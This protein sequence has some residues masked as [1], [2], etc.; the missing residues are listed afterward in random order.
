MPSPEPGWRAPYY[1]LALFAFVATAIA[2]AAY[3]FYVDQN[4]AVER[5]FQNELLTIAEMKAG[6][7]AAWRSERIGSA[8]VILEDRMALAALNRIVT[9]ASS[10]D[11][12]AEIRDWMNGICRHLR[13]ANAIL[14]DRQGAPLLSAGQPFGN[15]NHYRAIAEEVLRAGELVMRDFHQDVPSGKVHLGLNFPLRLTPDAEPFGAFLLGI[16]PGD[17]LY[18]V[19]Q[20]WPVLSTTGET[21]LVRREGDKVVYLNDVGKSVPLQFSL[22]ITRTDVA[23]VQAVLGTEGIV[24]ALDYRGVPVIA[25]VRRVPQTPWYIVAKVGAAEVRANALQR[26]LDLGLLAISLI[27]AAGGGVAFVWRRQQLRSY[28]ER[29]EAAVAHRALLGRYD[30]LLRFANDTIL[31]ADDTGRIVEANDRASSTYGY[32]REELQEMS[33]RDLWH[34]NAPGF[35]REWQKT[36]D[37]GSDLFETVHRS[38]NGGEIPVE[39]SARLIEVG[40]KKFCQSIIRDISERKH[41]DAEKFRLEQQLAQAQKMESIGRLAGG[42]AHD[43]NNHLTVISGYCNLVLEDLPPADPRREAIEEIRRAGDRAAALTRQLLAFSRK[44]IATPRSVDLNEVIAESG[45]ML[46]RLIGEDI[47][48][49]TR[50]A[51]QPCCVKA[52]PAQM[53]QILMNLAVNARDA[54]PDGGRIRIETTGATVDESGAGLHAVKPGRYVLLTVSDT[55][56]GMNPETLAQIFEP[57]FTTKGVGLGTG[58]GLAT[59]YGIVRQSGGW[60]EAHSEPGHG[61]TFQIYL[62]RVESGAEPVSP[63]AAA[64]KPGGARVLV[65]EDEPQLRKLAVK[66]LRRLGYEVMEAADGPAALSLCER[67]ADPIDLLMTDVIMPGMNGRE[68][69]DKLLASRPGLHVL[70]VSGYTASV[71]ENEGRLGRGTAY[72]A[73]PYSPEQLS[74]KVREILQPSK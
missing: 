7:M 41:A 12:R 43:F 55:G 63:T 29:Y 24:R 61:A 27:L 37:S 48:I 33:L 9:G 71:I 74:A 62:P 64:A 44:Q 52:D 39:V 59:V 2:G 25:G 15:R 4:A 60:I 42:V 68:L 66:M 28:K 51:A 35:E 72:L 23:G 67:Y 54:M 65:V 38:K 31:L 45:K 17:Y 6:Q 20:R 13:F 18:P 26:S 69:A 36:R 73:K 21:M 53:T 56:I 58:L 11:E 16:D 47:E 50:A 22:P 8:K 34:P 3:H 40:E 49:V 19:L 32:T 14:V 30:Y 1:L 10:A 70:Y 46:R 5:E 57:F